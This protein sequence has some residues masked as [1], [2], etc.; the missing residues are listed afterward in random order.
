MNINQYC[1]VLNVLNVISTDIL[2]F[3]FWGT[4]IEFIN[5]EDTVS[6]GIVYFIDKD[7]ALNFQIGNRFLR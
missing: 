7:E 4:S 3:T 6:A 2:G 5:Q 1:T